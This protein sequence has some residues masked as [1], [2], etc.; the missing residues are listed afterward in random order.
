M[1][2]SKKPLFLPSP[3]TTLDDFFQK[4][5]TSVNRQSASSWAQKRVK[6]SRRS[7]SQHRPRTKGVPRPAAEII[8]IDSDD[9]TPLT[10]AKRKAKD[11]SGCSS[12]VEVVEVDAITQRTHKAHVPNSG[13]KAKV[14]SKHEPDEFGTHDLSTLFQ[15][16]A[17]ESDKPQPFRPTEDSVQDLIVGQDFQASSSISLDNQRQIATPVLLSADPDDLHRPLSEIQGDSSVI[18]PSNL[19]Q[20]GS[21]NVIEIDDEWGTGDDELVQMNGVEVDGALELT[22]DE[23]EA[24]LKPEDESPTTLD[25]TTDQCPFCGITLTILS[26]T[27][28]FLA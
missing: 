2:S 18:L 4:P 27:V 23:V 6:S 7:C 16:D 12:D 11:D 5:E 20:I 13:K 15:D 14:E 1:A 22:D 3:P 19:S 10:C 8:V 28:S 17:S 9:D 25:E 26:T 24:I 21:D